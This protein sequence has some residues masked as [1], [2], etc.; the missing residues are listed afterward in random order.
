MLRITLAIMIAA[1]VTIAQS[2]AAESYVSLSRAVVIARVSPKLVD[3]TK[4]DP[5]PFAK[6]FKAE[7]LTEDDLKA[8]IKAD[9][10]EPRVKR[11]FDKL[12][13]L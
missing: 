11:C 12:I 2:Q 7:G 1:V 8:T 13:G 5:R 4:L 6:C 9:S 3:T 10:L